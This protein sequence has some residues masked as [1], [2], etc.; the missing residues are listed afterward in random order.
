MHKDITSP[1]FPSFIYSDP[2]RAPKPKEC[3]GNHQKFSDIQGLLVDFGIHNFSGSSILTETNLVL[4]S[5]HSDIIVIF[6]LKG[7]YRGVG[8]GTWHLAGSARLGSAGLMMLDKKLQSQG[9]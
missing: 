6:S 7:A 3:L 4:Y 2:F 5:D 9:C 8:F 1:Y